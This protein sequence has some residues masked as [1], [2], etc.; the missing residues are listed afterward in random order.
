MTGLS[1]VI[2]YTYFLA[3]IITS[4]AALPRACECKTCSGIL[5]T[6]KRFDHF[7]R[8]VALEQDVVTVGIV[9]TTDVPMRCLNTQYPFLA[10]RFYDV[11]FKLLFK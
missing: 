3:Y 1:V 9:L 11:F 6:A 8:A 2:L 7:K 5:Y 4:F 10:S